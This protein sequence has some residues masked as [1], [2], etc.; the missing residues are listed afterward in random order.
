M[1]PEEIGEPL[2]VVPC[3]IWNRAFGDTKDG[4]MVQVRLPDGRIVAV[5]Q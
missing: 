1:K 5:A 3:E 2:V 4:D